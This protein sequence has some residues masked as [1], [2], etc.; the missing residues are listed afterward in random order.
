MI[1]ELRQR[2]KDRAERVNGVPMI[3]LSQLKPVYDELE[4][5][6]RIG[7]ELQK[8]GLVYQVNDGYRFKEPT[9]EQ[10]A[11]LWQLMWG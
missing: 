1:E 8:T 10:A 5:L 11:Q 7:L 6:A 2:V 3:A 4:K 9:A